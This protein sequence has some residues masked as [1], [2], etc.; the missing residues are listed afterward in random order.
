MVSGTSISRFLKDE[1]GVV[2]VDWVAITAGIA[3]IGG[4]IGYTVLNGAQSV[5]D[6]IGFELSELSNSSGMSQISD[7]F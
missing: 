5:G 7:G 2:T 3:I 6:A 1:S 4:F